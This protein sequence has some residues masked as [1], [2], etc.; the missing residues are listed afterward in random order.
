[1][2]AGLT[3]VLKA[4]CRR[5]A[6][7]THCV[8]IHICNKLGGQHSALPLWYRCACNRCT[9][10]FHYSRLYIYFTHTTYSLFPIEPIRSFVTPLFHCDLKTIPDV[11]Y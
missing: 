1:M 8:S 7:A 3:H 9:F 5:R 6:P 4:G 11:K 2:Q 10:W